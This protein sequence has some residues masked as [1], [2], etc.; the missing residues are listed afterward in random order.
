MEFI[1]TIASNSIVCIVFLVS[2]FIY[3]LVLPFCWGNNPMDYRGTLSH[4][5]EHHKPF[6]WIWAFL[7]GGCFLF[8]AE[9]M[10]IK[11][12]YSN[13]FL[14]VLLILA[15]LGMFVIAATL[16]HSIE[17]WNP[18][19]VVHWTGTILYIV[20]IALAVL[21]FFLL[22][23]N[24]RGFKVLAGIMV[25]IIVGFIVWFVKLGR[26]AVIEMIPIASVEI[27][28]FVV[29]FTPLVQAS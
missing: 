14:D 27:M 5:C 29:N 11:V 23:L 28:M 12:G 7:T 13:R 3:G 19:R 16:E 21:L 4:L 18:T 20:C 2:A 26:S 9:H 25:F 15:V 6:F 1:R 10:F 22:N 8:N 17:N 24:V